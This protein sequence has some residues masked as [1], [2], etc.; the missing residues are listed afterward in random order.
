MAEHHGGMGIAVGED[1]RLVADIVSWVVTAATEAATRA[2]FARAPPVFAKLTPEYHDIVGL[3]KA[4]ATTGAAGVTTTNTFPS[5]GD[6][7][8]DGS[9]WPQWEGK[10]TYS[11]ASGSVLRPI[12]LRKT[13]LVSRALPG[14]LNVSQFQFQSVPRTWYVSSYGMN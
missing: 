14:V 6:V 1:P 4:A 10:A 5:L 3:A 9:S 8:R 12:A 11:G 13:S 2:G 7:A